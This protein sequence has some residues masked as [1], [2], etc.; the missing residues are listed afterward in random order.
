M[1][2]FGH[3]GL[4]ELGFRLRL[5]ESRNGHL[6]MASRAPPAPHQLVMLEEGVG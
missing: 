6:L 3:L 5:H 4:Q 1:E 2:D